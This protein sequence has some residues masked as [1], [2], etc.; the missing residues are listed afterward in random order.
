MSMGCRA[1]DALAAI[2]ASSGV[3]LSAIPSMTRMDGFAGSVHRLRPTAG[4]ATSAA[5]PTT[6]LAPRGH[7]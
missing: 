4:R 3:G 2:K 1:A 5:Y 6:C 7:P